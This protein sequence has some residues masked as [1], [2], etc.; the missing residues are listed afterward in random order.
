M[1]SIETLK[2]LGGV[3]PCRDCAQTGTQAVISYEEPAKVCLKC[4]GTGQI[5]DLAPL[6]AKPSTLEAVAVILLKIEEEVSTEGLCGCCLRKLNGDNSNGFCSLECQ[7]RWKT[8]HTVSGNAYGYAMDSGRGNYGP[9]SGEKPPA[10]VVIQ[11]PLFKERLANLHVVCPARCTTL[12]YEVARQLGG[13]A[14]V[15]EPKYRDYVCDVPCFHH[16]LEVEGYNLSLPIPPDSAVLF[17]T[18]RLDNEKKYRL[19]DSIGGPSKHPY[20]KMQEIIHTVAALATRPPEWRY[21]TYMLC[22]VD[23][24]GGKFDMPYGPH[25]GEWQVIYLHQEN[26]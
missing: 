22:L 12:G 7:D 10:R 6:L 24:T 14:V 19:T 25:E 26:P 20:C 16:T 8:T 11:K 13:T 23:D 5:I 17:V 18:D 3:R 1:N 2:H 9:L 15:A 4:H 21:L